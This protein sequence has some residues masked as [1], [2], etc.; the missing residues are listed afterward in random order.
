MD[1]VINSAAYVINIP[2]GSST[3]SSPGALVHVLLLPGTS[4]RTSPT[5]LHPQTLSTGDKKLTS[6][7]P[8]KGKRHCNPVPT[9]I[10]VLSPLTYTFIF[11][12][13]ANIDYSWDIPI[14]PKLL[15]TLTLRPF[16]PIEL[17]IATL[18]NMI[19]N[20]TQRNPCLLV[21]LCSKNTPM[22]YTNQEIHNLTQIYV[23]LFLFFRS[24]HR[25]AKLIHYMVVTSSTPDIGLRFPRLCPLN[26]K[27]ICF[28]SLLMWSLPFPPSKIR[29]GALLSRTSCP[30]SSLFSSY[31][32]PLR[33]FLSI[34]PTSSSVNPPHR[35]SPIFRPSK[36]Y[37]PSN[38]GRPMSSSVF[39]PQR[40]ICRFAP[41]PRPVRLVV[42]GLGVGGGAKETEPYTSISTFLENSRFTIF[43]IRDT[44]P[45][46]NP[47][48]KWD[49]YEHHYSR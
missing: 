17:F 25:Y 11:S 46:T 12:L 36:S 1:T 43:L 38:F 3:I 15:S 47:T 31:L 6:S 34:Q 20:Y 42:L 24:G 9:Q 40:P 19:L 22:E 41:P 23:Y 28:P 32:P 4:T 26:I 30:S 35:P 21:T 39:H 7:T 49:P 37:Q 14:P 16:A 27:F 8:S 45:I 5:K 33:P 2:P 10:L 18:M 29:P 44:D 13:K 48:S